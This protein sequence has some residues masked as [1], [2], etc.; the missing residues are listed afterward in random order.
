MSRLLDDLLDVARLTRNQLRIERMPLDV[1]AL[2]RDVAAAWQAA[3][4]KKGLELRV[5]A[6]EHPLTVNGDPVRLQQVIS[7]LLANAVRY[8]HEGKVTL[9][10]RA[11][12]D[13]ALVAVRDTGIGMAPGELSRAFELFYQ[14]PQSLD[15]SAGGLGLGLS[16]AQRLA[17]L[18]GGGISASSDG[19][20]RGSEFVVRLPLARGAAASPGR[21]G[22]E[23][24]PRRLRVAIVEDNDDIRETMREILE[25]E[26]HEV[27]EAATGPEGAQLVVAERPHVALVDVGLPGL[28]GYGVARRVREALGGAVRLVA[29]TGYGRPEDRARAIAA[30]FDAHAVKPLEAGGLLRLLAQ[31]AT[32]SVKSAADGAEAGA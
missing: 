11:E 14:A 12:R 10:V 19:P 28:D 31:E 29:L 4:E 32:P 20:G 7:N 26:G 24:R 22:V 16:L 5:D 15:R 8:T 27:L 3:A 21:D 23:R 30:G 17:E 13:E 25:L 1:A 2:A 9:A 18:H 6:P